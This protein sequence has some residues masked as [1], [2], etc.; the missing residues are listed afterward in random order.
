MGNICTVFNDNDVNNQEVNNHD[1]NTQKVNT[2]KVNNHEVNTQKVNNQEVNILE[3]KSQEEKIKELN[4]SKKIAID[5]IDKIIKDKEFLKPI[6]DVTSIP[7]VEDIKFM[8]FTSDL[9][10]PQIKV[11]V[12]TMNESLYNNV[13]IFTTLYGTPYYTF[14]NNSKLNTSLNKDNTANLKYRL[15]VIDDN[16]DSIKGI[17]LADIT[18]L[19][20]KDETG[21]KELTNEQIMFY[22][23]E[24]N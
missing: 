8:T 15:L 10:K 11:L 21:Q 17:M 12:H 1:V 23:K 19:W 5:L 24:L 9:D 13:C 3:E 16:N 2:Q 22:I 14:I 18:T 4:E 6:V 20:T 7:I